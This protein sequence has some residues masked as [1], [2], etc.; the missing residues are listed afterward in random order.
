MLSRLL[1]KNFEEG[2]IHCI[3]HPVGAPLVSHLLYANDLLVFVNGEKR[4]MRRLVKILEIYEKWSGQLIDK[5][6]SAHFFSKKIEISR[7]RSLIMLTGFMEGKFR[8]TY[9]GILLVSG[10]L[11]SR[12]LE[13]LVTKIRN[14][15][16]GWK[17]RLLS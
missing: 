14:K 1:W 2:Q 10:R 11:T 12:D 15:V 13:A 9:L 5:D 8:V 7:W 17:L 6:K 16:T 3:S 4:S